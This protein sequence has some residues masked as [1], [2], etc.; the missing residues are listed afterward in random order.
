MTEKIPSLPAVVV[1]RVVVVV[2]VAFV[3]VVVLATE[4]QIHWSGQSINQSINEYI[5]ICIVSISEEELEEIYTIYTKVCE[6]PF[7]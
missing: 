1:A 4:K 7:I 5:L 6:H 2:V 3:V